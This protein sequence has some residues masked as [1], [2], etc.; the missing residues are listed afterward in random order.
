VRY[1][2]EDAHREGFIAVVIEDACRAID[3]DGSAAAT[4]DLFRKLGIACVTANAS[5]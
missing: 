5:G 4:R 3:L 2:A 1:S